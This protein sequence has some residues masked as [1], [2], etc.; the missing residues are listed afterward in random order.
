MHVTVVQVRIVRVPVRQSG[1]RVPV[2]V[3][4]TRR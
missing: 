4:L 2:G 1:V 3:R